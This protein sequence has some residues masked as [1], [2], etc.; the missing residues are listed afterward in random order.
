MRKL[1]FFAFLMMGIV[2]GGY[3]QEVPN[4]IKM[5]LE[6][7]NKD[8]TVEG[9]P[10]YAK[11][12]RFLSDTVKIKDVRVGRILQEYA[13]KHVFLD[14]YPDT[15]DFSEIIE[16]TGRWFVLI[17]VRSKPA[18]ELWLRLDKTEGKVIYAGMS[19][20]SPDGGMWGVL[21]KA[22]PVSMGINPI[23]LTMFNNPYLLYFKQIGPRKLCYYGA[24]VKDEHLA[25]RLPGPI[26]IL[27]DS[28]RFIEYL[29]AQGVN[30]IGMSRERMLE[31]RRQ[32]SNENRP[33][34][35]GRW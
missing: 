5:F 9:G 15:V 2:G 8:S 20:I 34:K 23:Y 3:T 21:E 29:R 12:S 27:G 14:A 19:E 7:Y 1:M 26:G 33:M 25:E 11:K 18:Y 17:T 16:P 24:G 35:M 32:E 30:E 22:Y 6:N 28:K 10:L 31:K 4:E 13:F